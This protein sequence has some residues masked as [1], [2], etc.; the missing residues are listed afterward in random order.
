L[1]EERWPDLDKSLPWELGIDEAGRGPVLGP[2]IYG[3]AIGL[4]SDRDALKEKKF[5]DSKAL[6]ETQREAMYSQIQVDSDLGY[7]T[8]IL[9]AELICG[10]MLGKHHKYDLN[11]LS[12]DC[13]IGMI[14]YVLDKGFNV[15]EVFVD[16]VG[17]PE[18][19]EAKLSR[20]FPKI[21]FTVRPKAD[22][23]FP[24]VSAA[25]IMAKVA[26]DRLVS[27]YEQQEPGRKT[28][29]PLGSGYPADPNTKKWLA[30]SCDPL[31]GYPKVARFSWSTVVE[32]L[33]EHAYPVDYHDEPVDEKQTS[34]LGF[35]RPDQHPR[36]KYFTSRNL[37]VVTAF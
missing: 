29:V 7:M 9:S 34:I 2:M 13:A 21:N 28:D 18:T 10:G 19:Y 24:C 22:A 32:H 33:K 3:V 35:A 1:H 12:H 37:A 36:K 25:S 23:L 11:R 20:E 5:D 16:T 6:T 8:R 14:R 15:T 26:R 27:G 30:E 31:F 17:R 4:V